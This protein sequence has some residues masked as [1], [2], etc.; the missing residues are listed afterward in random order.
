MRPATER[1]SA[2]GAAEVEIGSMHKAGGVSTMLPSEA[3]AVPA[4]PLTEPTTKQFPHGR[5][6]G[7]YLAGTTL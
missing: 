5:L 4:M 7:F 2:T 6:T 1:P 3:A